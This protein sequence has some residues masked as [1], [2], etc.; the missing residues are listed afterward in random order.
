M[1]RAVSVVC[2]ALSLIWHSQQ[3]QDIMFYN[4]VVLGGVATVD[5]LAL[6]KRSIT[7]LITVGSQAPYF[8]EIDALV[9]RPFGAGLPRYFPKKWLNIFDPNDFFSY[10]AAK[11][12]PGVAVDKRVDNGQPFPESHSAYWHNDAAVWPAIKESVPVPL[13]H[14]KCP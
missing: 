1:Q 7:R 10:R 12:F 4:I 5:W 8:Y 9:S 11:I 2:L 14:E 6:G 13:R 3:N